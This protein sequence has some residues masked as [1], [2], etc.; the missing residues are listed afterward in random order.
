MNAFKVS[1]EQQSF[2]AQMLYVVLLMDIGL[3]LCTKSS[4]IPTYRICATNEKKDSSDHIMHDAL[5]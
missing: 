1:E 5:K 2:T 3:Q 4:V